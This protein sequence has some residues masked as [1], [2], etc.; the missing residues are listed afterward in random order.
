MTTQE[1][2]IGQPE[3]VGSAGAALAECFRRE[4]A[5]YRQM[6]EIMVRQ[7]KALTVND[8]ETTEACIASEEKTLRQLAHAHK[9]S[10]AVLAH[11][12]AQHGLDETATV[13]E[14]LE[15]VPEYDRVELAESRDE[16][17]LAAGQ[18]HREN[19]MN[20][21]LLTNAV[22]YI[23]FCMRLFGGQEQALAYGPEGLETSGSGSLALDLKA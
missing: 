11:L 8:V 12:A 18:V 10:S 14:L 19:G 23:N 2:T 22:E 3:E 20:A 21:A 17:L 13:S 16:L 6:L 5:L 1:Q 4:A 7:R 15:V 9:R